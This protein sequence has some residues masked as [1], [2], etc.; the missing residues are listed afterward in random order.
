MNISTNYQ[1]SSYYINLP[2]ITPNNRSINPSNG[3]LNKVDPNSPAGKVE[4]QTCKTRR[5]VDGSDDPGVSFK[6]PGYISPEASATTVMSHEREHV[7][8]EKAKALKDNREILYQ[9]IKLESSI[10]PECGKSY[11][12]GGT[13]TTVS[14][15]SSDKKDF[16]IENYE[17]KMSSYFGKQIDLKV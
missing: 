5:Y 10:C 12:S 3:D 6:T 9:S 1:Q 17:K 15:G 11:V 16:F 14:K 13:T 2:N 7:S 4:C 8:N